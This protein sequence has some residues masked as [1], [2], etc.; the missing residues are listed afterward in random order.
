MKFSD[1]TPL[2]GWLLSVVAF[3]CMGA[4]TGSANGALIYSLRFDKP[5]HE[6]PG[7]GPVIVGLILREEAT[8]TDTPR[9]A[10]QRLIKGNVQVSWTGGGSRVLN[11]P[12]QSFGRG[13]DVTF[14]SGMSSTSATLNARDPLLATN[15]AITQSYDGVEVGG[16]AGTVISPSIY[17]VSLGTLKFTVPSAPD[18][19]NIKFDDLGSGNLTIGSTGFNATNFGTAVVGNPE[20]STFILSGM[21]ILGAVIMHRLRQRRAKKQAVIA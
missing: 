2:A 12:E 19:T 21:S 15:V 5:A 1:R 16:A 18:S 13:G 4:L 3:V 6:V 7:G 20:P 17:E 8:N 11:V 9:L 10:S 14:A